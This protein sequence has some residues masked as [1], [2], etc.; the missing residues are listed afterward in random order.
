VLTAQDDNS[1]RLPDDQLR[2]RARELGRTLF[3]QDSDLLTEA[4]RRQRAGISF[5]GVVFAPQ[6]AITVGQAI[7]ELELIAKVYEP[8]D[9]A[10]RVEFLPLE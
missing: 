7:R 2:D 10:D 6:L 4:T 8:D 5:P 9:I 3:S 1:N